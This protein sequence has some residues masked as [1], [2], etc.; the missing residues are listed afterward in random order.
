MHPE[1]L[2]GSSIWICRCTHGRVYVGAFQLV[3]IGDKI[4]A[5]LEP[6]S[7]GTRE[8]GPVGMEKDQLLP[9]SCLH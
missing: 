6:F 7:G 9:C 3:L 1:L 2:T 4:E 8:Y 5:D